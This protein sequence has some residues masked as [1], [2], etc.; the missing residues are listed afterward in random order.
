MVTLIQEDLVILTATE[1]LSSEI[2]EVS[3]T[4]MLI[5]ADS[6]IPEM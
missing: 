2:V 5:Q 6:E 1:I 3:E 4:V